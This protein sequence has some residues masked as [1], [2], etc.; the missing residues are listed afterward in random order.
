[1]QERVSDNNVMI[2]GL[3]RLPKEFRAQLL[4]AEKEIDGDVSSLP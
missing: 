1:M 3:A 2:A 4:G